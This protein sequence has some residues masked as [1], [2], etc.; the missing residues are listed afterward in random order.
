MR[1]NNVCFCSEIGKLSLNYPQLPLIS[2]A[3][4]MGTLSEEPS[5]PF[6]FLP[7]F[8]IGVNAKSKEFAL[9]GS[10]QMP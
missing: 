6:S 5:L 7:L 3:L 2:A 4:R 10:L 8:S 1:G 9:L